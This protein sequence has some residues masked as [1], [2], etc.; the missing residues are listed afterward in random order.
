MLLFFGLLCDFG[1]PLMLAKPILN[2]LFLFSSILSPWYWQVVHLIYGIEL[3]VRRTVY[4]RHCTVV[5]CR[6][7]YICG[8]HNP[9]PE[10]VL[11]EFCEILVSKCLFVAAGGLSWALVPGWRVDN[12]CIIL[13]NCIYNKVS[14][15]DRFKTNHSRNACYFL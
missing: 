9:P 15:I 5:L 2:T 10:A 6:R 1:I 13:L 4:N 14:W 12:A 3:T 11:L 8:T 7:Y